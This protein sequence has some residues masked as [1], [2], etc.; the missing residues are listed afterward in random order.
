MMKLGVKVPQSGGFSTGRGGLGAGGWGVRCA[1]LYPRHS[2]HLAT[3]P[4]GEAREPRKSREEPRCSMDLL[5]RTILKN[6]TKR[7]S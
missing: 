6:L 7:L 4:V 1:A 2:H 5:Q 3:L